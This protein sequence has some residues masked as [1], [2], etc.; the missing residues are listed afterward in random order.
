MEIA[1]YRY[2]VELLNPLIITSTQGYKGMSYTIV[3]DYI[4]GSMVRGAIFTHFLIEKLVSENDIGLEAKSPRHSVTPALPIP[5]ELRDS[6]YL[7][8]DAAFAH[9]LTYTLKGGGDT[10]FSLGIENILKHVSK[11]VDVE[12]AIEKTVFESSVKS[13]VNAYKN[14]LSDPAEVFGS[15][16]ER[17]NACGLTVVK[18][19]GRWV[20]YKPK[21]GIYVET[22]VDRSR[23]SAAHG[24]L[25]AYEYIEPGNIFTGFVSVASDS[26]VAEAFK[27]IS[28][29]CIV[30]RIGR[31]L[32]RGFGLSRICIEGI[33]A[34]DAMSEAVDLYPGRFVAMYA[35]SPMFLVNPMPRPIASGDEIELNVFGTSVAKVVVCSVI[36]KDPVKYYGWSYRHGL[37]KLPIVANP[38]GSLAIVTI[39]S[40]YNKDF[41]K[42]LALTGFNNFSAQGF[43]FVKPLTQDFFEVV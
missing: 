7:L 17:E 38:P 34:F 11:C 29:S 42:L 6:A 14:A 21:R 25:Y 16:T 33:A 31:G 27:S 41:A 23:G 5:R 22:A 8:R 32:G 15:S 9:A 19:D 40:V 24:M 18:R 35:T 12:K 10:V 28:K 39:N 30:A 13:D 26:K 4:P 43:N 36:G 20:S 3:S 37:P 1:M 2:V